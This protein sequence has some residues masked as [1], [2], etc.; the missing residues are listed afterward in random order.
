MRAR[1]FLMWLLILT[2]TTIVAACQPVQA[3]SAPPIL[4]AM[5]PIVAFEVTPVPTSTLVTTPVSQSESGVRLTAIIDTLCTS[6]ARPDT[7]CVRPYAGEFVVTKLNYAEVTRIATNH[8]GQ[9][10]VELPPGKYI[11]GVRTEGI[12]P[13]AAPIKVDV[14]A[15]HYEP[16]SFSLDSGRWR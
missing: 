8:E 15:D 9:A 12:Y 1:T 16:I 11:L 2:V 7:G 13:L 4:P 10:T 14:V 5:V 6:A 3:I